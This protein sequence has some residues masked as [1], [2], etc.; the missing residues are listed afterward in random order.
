MTKL[1]CVLIQNIT[2]SIIRLRGTEQLRIFRINMH[3]DTKKYSLVQPRSLHPTHD[4]LKQRLRIII[5][6]LMIIV[7]IYRSSHSTSS[8]TRQCSCKRWSDDTVLLK[9]HH[10]H[11]SHHQ[12]SGSLYT[13]HASKINRCI[14]ILRT[15]TQS[16]PTTLDICDH[17]YC[18]AFRWHL[19]LRQA[20]VLNHKHATQCTYILRLG[21][22]KS[23]QAVE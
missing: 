21:S 1:H 7:M 6:V 4:L 5:I 3:F 10:E 18:S 20:H 19:I 16:L 13:R 22:V 11:N 15:I 8:V 17:L 9:Y 23:A 12:Y 14:I 2:T